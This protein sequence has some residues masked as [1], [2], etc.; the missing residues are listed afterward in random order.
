[1]GLFTEGF[2]GIR[3]IRET[4]H[5]FNLGY[6]QMHSPIGRFLPV[7]LALCAL[8]AEPFDNGRGLAL[9]PNGGI[10]QEGNQE[11]KKPAQGPRIGPIQSGRLKDSFPLP[12][13]NLWKLQPTRRAPEQ[14]ENAG[15]PEVDLTGSGGDAPAGDEYWNPNIDVQITQEIIDKATELGTPLKMYEFVRN[16]CEFQAYYGSQKGSVET[17]RQKSGNDYDLATLLIALLRAGGHAAR[18]AVGFV[19][20]TPQQAIDWLAVDDPRVAGSILTTSGMEG[21]TIIG[22]GNVVVGVRCRR[23]WVEA[24]IPRGRS[25]PTW[26]PLDPAFKGHTIHRGLDIPNE[27]SLDAQAFVDDYYDPADPT[28]TLPR[29]ETLIDLLKTRLESYLAASHPEMT[30]E[31]VRRTQEISPEQIAALPASMP[32]I[33]RTRDEDFAEI[34]T[35]R[36]YTLRIHIYGDSTDLDHTVNL[37]D[38]AGRR[39]TI[40]FVAATPADQ[41]TIDSYGGLYDTPPYLVN[42]KPVL[43]LDGTELAMASIGFGMGRVLQSDIYFN[44]PQNS[45]GLPSNEVPL[46]QNTII[47]GASQAVG[48]GVQG[49]SEPMTIPPPEDDTEGMASLLQDTSMDYM[50]EVRNGDLELARLMHC[51]VTTGVTSAIV[52]NVVNVTYD[53]WGNPQTFEWKGLRVDA[54]RSI[55]GVWPVDELAPDDGEPKD[56]MII[57]GAEGSLFENRIFENSYEQASVSTM[58]ILQLA[59]AGGVPIYKRWSSTILP[60]GVTLSASDRSAIISAISSGHV[61]TFHAQPITAG[62]PDT[63]QWTGA[64]WIDMDPTNGAAGYIISGNHNGGATVEYW[65]PAFI[66]L[67]NG[68][69]EVSGAKIFM[70]GGESPIGDSPAPEAIFTRDNEEHLIFE[71]QV[72]VT[73]TDG[74]TKTLPSDSTYFQ[75]ETRNT[76]KTFRPGNY[77]FEVWISRW[78]F[79]TMD[80]AERNVSIVGVLIREDDGTEYGKE[81]PKVISIKSST[82]SDPIPSIPIKALVIPEKAPDNVTT[83]AISFSWSASR[84]RFRFTSPPGA[85]EIICETEQP[86]S[87]VDD[88][89]VNLNVSIVGLKTVKG[90]AKFKYVA[91]GKDE[92]YMLTIVKIQPKEISFSGNKYHVL[93]SD[94]GTKDYTAPHWQDNSSPLDGD[95]ND[96]SDRKY[97][98]CFTQ[99]TKMKVS[100]RWWVDPGLPPAPFS[101]QIRGSGPSALSI[102][103]TTCTING[104]E[105]SI[106]DVECSS[107]FADSVGFFDPLEITWNYLPKSGSTWWGAG[108]TLNQTYVTLGDPVTTPVFHTLAHLG[109][110]NA[111][112]MNQPA[113]VTEA[114]WGEFADQC[115]RRIDGRQ[116]T[117]YASYTCSNTSTAALLSNGD[118]QCGAWAK[119]FIDLRKVQGIDDSN[120]YVLFE[121]IADDGF[122]VKNW[123]FSGTG[124]SGNTTYPYLNVTDSFL[125]GL[126][127]YNF[128]FAEVKDATGV[129]GQGNSNPASLFNNH[130]VVIGGVY[131]DPS[132]GIKYSTLQDID[133]SI[134][135]FYIGPGLY[136]V[137][138]PTVNLDLNGDRDKTDL[139]VNT[140]VILFRKNLPGLDIS[141][142]RFD[143]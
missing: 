66:D 139:G 55:L 9:D 72:L 124:L 126:T 46:I 140:E 60:G 78:I 75:R 98:I 71:Y 8:G 108:E 14:P 16:E 85:Y 100:A 23:V 105:I 76:T 130:Q 115:V 92:R 134:D 1:M 129:A 34:P 51:H 52:E 42:L 56:F 58:K 103:V 48:I 21:I 15:E 131:Y 10:R 18:Y 47:C 93:K 111:A 107:P 36:R 87:T 113:E 44:E 120:E 106:K 114:I 86:S 101:I 143:Y 122:I 127:K 62:E 4:C 31:D 57:S 97:P 2:K 24:Y 37:P 49:Y 68:D 6:L 110:K 116:L 50:A 109:C 138:E 61:V 118:G 104:S 17:L 69:K 79:W 70:K 30:L 136:P 123:T 35:A 67:S 135:G 11:G 63:G 99:N 133:N 39:I 141:E 125:I 26:V 95:A 142:R 12:L 32:Y 81:L 137:N 77:K 73:Y 121:P 38:I 40:D 53:F 128:R 22:S 74:S 89:E 90:Y 102:P 7:V 112:G 45:Q 43:R 132:Y 59:K 82:P 119:L 117:Y 84:L 41:A 94:D 27:M 5:S 96:S 13:P 54:D 19:D 20:L 29:P 88:Q 91:G 28:V 25:S 80:S 33:V 83:I 3:L 65:P 64:G